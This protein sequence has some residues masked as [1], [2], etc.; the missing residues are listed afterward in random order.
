MAE[1]KFDYDLY[2]ATLRTADSVG[3]SVVSE[4]ELAR[5]LAILHVAGNNEKMTHSY[6]FRAE[7]TFAQEKYHLRGGERPVKEFCSLIKEYVK[8]L[9][10]YESL[11]NTYPKWAYDLMRKRYGVN[12]F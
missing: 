7:V 5:S 11:H 8:E 4:D 1:L 6:K 9:E 12:L 3:M 2:L 10:D